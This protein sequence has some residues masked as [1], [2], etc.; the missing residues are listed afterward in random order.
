MFS[1]SNPSVRIKPGT[2]KGRLVKS[3][4]GVDIEQYLGIP[5][6]KSPVGELRFAKPEPQQQFEG[7]KGTSHLLVEKKIYDFFRPLL[8]VCD[9]KICM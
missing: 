1:D 5:F 8:F 7:G 2:V 9:C 4:Q 3:P 6:A